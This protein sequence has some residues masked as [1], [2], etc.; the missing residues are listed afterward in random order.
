MG[1]G[2]ELYVYI[3][4]P[5]EPEFGPG[6]Q[7]SNP[8]VS[9]REE[10]ER[11]KGQFLASLNHEIRTPLSGVLGMTDL[12]LETELTEEQ[13]EY[14]RSTR[15]CANSLLEVLNSVL[16]YSALQA[17]M[18]R[19][20]TT[21]FSPREL[22]ETL[23]QETRE[24]AASKGLQV[25]LIVDAAVPATVTGSARHLRECLWQILQNALKFTNDGSIELTV[26]CDAVEAHSLQGTLRFHV[27]DTGI[28]IPS[29]QL[30][31]IFESFTQLDN[32]L[33]RSYS[34][35]GLG[36][37]IADKLVR[38][39]GGLIHAESCSGEGSTFTIVVPVQMPFGEPAAA[40]PHLVRRG[41]SSGKRLLLVDDNK[42]AQQ[43]MQHVL[44]R[45]QYEVTITDCGEDAVVMAREHEFDLVLMDLQMPRQ[46][47]FETAAA[48]RR[49]PHHAH[50]PIL[51]VSAN[52]QEEQ[53]ERFE[54][55]GMQGFIPKPINRQVLLRSV[56]H[57]LQARR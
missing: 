9:Q 34:G 32:G 22:V 39:M 57:A 56:E 6:T 28:G 30:S 18:Y 4:L 8:V 50:T 27:R 55:S 51:A 12:L 7:F 1:N 42:I 43:I 10:L 19:F 47:G 35:L 25:K 31:Q 15:E 29:E 52:S 37:A 21:E 38:K 48:I 46:D 11:L 40:R 16:A 3:P 17:G 23:A 33:A 26:T 13:A 24:R 20:E 54:K 53:R 14:V 41:Q 5:S 2:R 36:L 45:E 44:S 49:L